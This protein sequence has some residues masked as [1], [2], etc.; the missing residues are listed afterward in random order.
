[1]ADSSERELVVDATQPTWGDAGNV[2][3]GGGEGFGGIG[4][5]WIGFGYKAYIPNL[6]NSE[7][8][9]PFTFGNKES[10]Q[11][12]KEKCAALYLK[13]GTLNK[14][15][16]PAVPYA[17][18]GLRLYKAHVLSRDA[19]A[20]IDDRW[21]VYTLFSVQ[22]KAIVQPAM[23]KLKLRVGNQELWAMIRTKE[24]PSGKTHDGKDGE[25]NTV[26]YPDQV[27]YVA[28]VY[29]DEADAKAHVVVKPNADTA[30]TPQFPKGYTLE[31]WKVQADE[32][33]Q[34]YNETKSN[35]DAGEFHPDDV[36]L[37]L[38][39]VYDLR[40]SWIREAVKG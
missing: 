23:D 34:A 20:W 21:W 10:T 5:V 30:A 3:T 32:I 39:T 18:F 40:E 16:E 24:D 38:A 22:W 6:S 33:K 9:F 19:S 28:E 36:I 2:L 26:V 4:K 37:N 15:G 25:G 14:R 27:F 11:V 17:G 7:T 1:M 31:G 35:T 12:A 8:W 29:K 13:H